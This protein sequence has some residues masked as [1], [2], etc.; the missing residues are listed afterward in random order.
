MPQIDN[1]RRARA[2]ELL[3][4][5][6]LARDTNGELRREILVVLSDDETPHPDMRLA[7]EGFPISAGARTRS[8]FDAAGKNLGRGKRIDRE[9]RDYVFPQLIDVGLVERIHINSQARAEETGQL[10]VRGEHPVAKSPNSGYVLT[11]DAQQLLMEVT[12]EQWPGALSVWL[13]RSKERRQQLLKKRARDAVAVAAPSSKH[14]VLIEQC[15]D[16]LLASVA[17]GFELV[18]VDD[19]DGDR[20]QERWQDRLEDLDLVPDLDSRWPDA[21]LFSPT[22]Q[23]VWFVDA[24]ISDGEIDE[25]R[26]KDLRPW[27]EK[28][29]YHV[30][31]M[32]TAY[33]T[34]KRASSR[35]ASQANLAIGTTLWIAEDGGKLFEVQS[36]A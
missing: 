26:A 9:T 17:E 29:G 15:V 1:I 11:E 6:D 32:T 31:G 22:K 36:L 27:A 10:F 33:E 18:F 16:A 28:R 24:V 3:E 23:A 12:D 34:W 25:F 30:E 13:S 35:Q 20:V 2:Q 5:L 8:L 7:A 4:R 21:I 14:S 19:A